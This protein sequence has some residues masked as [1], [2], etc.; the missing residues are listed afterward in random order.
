VSARDQLLEALAEAAAHL[1]ALDPE[2]AAAS[3][4]RAVEVTAALESEGRLL[5]PSDRQQA[6]RL[7][8]A[9]EQAAGRVQA[10]LAASLESAG[11]SARALDAY[12][13]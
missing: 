1:E 5:D 8:A 9:C 2:G 13:R 11:R 10:A 4:G 6:L 3:L 7:H 12:R